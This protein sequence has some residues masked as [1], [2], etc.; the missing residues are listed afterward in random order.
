VAA[1]SLFAVL[2]AGASATASYTRL[3]RVDYKLGLWLAIAAL[4]GAALGALLAT[5]VPRAAF[6]GVVGILLVGVA[7]YLLIGPRRAEAASLSSTWT[8][9]RRV[10][11]DRRGTVYEYPLKRLAGGTICL[12]TGTISTMLGIGGGLIQVPLFVHVLRIPVHVAIA[13]SQVVITATALA[14]T[15]AHLMVGN[16]QL[17]WWNVGFLA[18]G[19]VLGAQVGPRL[20]T[21]FSGPRLAKLLAVGLLAVGTQSL[22]GLL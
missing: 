10:L 21:R 20:S 13:T 7:V 17:G 18:L 12:F 3:R 16:L 22:V 14:G 8:G 6:Q 5:Y 19:V 2:F 11:T 1:A 9:P 4:P 15:V